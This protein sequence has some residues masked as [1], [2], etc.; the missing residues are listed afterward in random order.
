MATTSQR[1]SKY[2]DRKLDFLLALNIE[3]YLKAIQ[4]KFFYPCLPYK[5]HIQFTKNIINFIS[6]KCM[7][8]F[9]KKLNTINT[10]S[11]IIME[12]W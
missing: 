8:L 4:K 2:Y 3:F 11:I 12:I 9:Q 5:I 10:T 6:I 1:Y 7:Q